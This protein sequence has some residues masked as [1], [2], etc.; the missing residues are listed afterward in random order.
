MQL[1]AKL[2]LAIA[3]HEQGLRQLYIANQDADRLALGN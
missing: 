3:G 2:L 1:N